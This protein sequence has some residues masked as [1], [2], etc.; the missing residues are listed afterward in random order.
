MAVQKCAAN[1]KIA[2][3]L[4]NESGTAAT[5]EDNSAAATKKTDDPAP[6]DQTDQKAKKSFWSRLFG[7]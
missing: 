7:K 2:D 4:D 6:I 5:E 1:V 3:D